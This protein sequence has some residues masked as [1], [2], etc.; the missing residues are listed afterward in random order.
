MA[1]HFARR[2]QHAPT[3]RHLTTT[4]S[5]RILPT[6]KEGEDITKHEITKKEITKKEVISDFLL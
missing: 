2:M 1:T 6:E 5:H 3:M 4:I